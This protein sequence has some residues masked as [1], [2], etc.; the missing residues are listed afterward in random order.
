MLTESSDRSVPS[1]SRTTKPTFGTLGAVDL[2]HLAVLGC[3]I[4]AAWFL[5]VRG[6]SR[7]LF[8]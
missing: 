6:M 4:A 3:C 2:L 1:S 8:D 5:A 7:R